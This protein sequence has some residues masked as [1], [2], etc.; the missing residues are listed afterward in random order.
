MQEVGAVQDWEVT[1]GTDTVVQHSLPVSAVTYHLKDVI[2]RLLV[3]NLV[4]CEQQTIFNLKILQS[5]DIKHLGNQ[6]K[7]GQKS[8]GLSSILIVFAPPLQVKE[9]PPC[10]PPSVP[11]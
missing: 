6:Y 3:S 1:T 5:S 4:G 9:S 7:S 8:M 2:D 11:N 10:A